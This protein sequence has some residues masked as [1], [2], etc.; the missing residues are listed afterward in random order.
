MEHLPIFFQA[1]LLLV[2]GYSHITTSWFRVRKQ[3]I[4][5]TIFLLLPIA[6]LP[7][8]PAKN[9]I[10]PHDANPIPWLLFLLIFCVGFPFFVVATSAP[11]VQKWF[12]QT[13]HP[14]SSDPYFLYTASNLGSML[15]S[16]QLPHLN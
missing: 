7:I 14:A 6:F 16:S 1:I 2:Y 13:G 3:A 5:H 15:G 9:W 12:A 4:L 8:T 10:P 11:L